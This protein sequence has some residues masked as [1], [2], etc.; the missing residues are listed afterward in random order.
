MTSY[1]RNDDFEAVELD[2]EWIILNSQAYTVTTLNEV[3]V[4]CWELLREKQTIDKMIQSIK[5]Q[6]TLE[7]EIETDIEFFLTDLIRCGLVEHES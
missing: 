7:E 3:G 4:Y 6:Y 1:I 2:E 5:G